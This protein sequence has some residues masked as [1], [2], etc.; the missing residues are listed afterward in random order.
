VRGDAVWHVPSV[1]MTTQASATAAPVSPSITVPW[2]LPNPEASVGNGGRGEALGDRLGVAGVVPH[3]ATT[4]AIANNS[5]T[6]R[7]GRTLLSADMRRVFPL[8]LIVALGVAAIF[9]GSLPGQPANAAVTFVTISGKITDASTGQPL[10]GACVAITAAG[11]TCLPQFPHTDTSGNYSISLPQGITW[12]FNFVACD[13]RT[14]TRNIVTD[15]TKVENQALTFIGSPKPAPLAGTPTN[16]VYLPN[17]TKTLGGATGWDTPF[18]VQNVDAANATNLE[19][20]FYRFSDG[21]LITRRIVNG[22]QS[23]RSFADIPSKDVDLPDSTQ[24][25]VVIRSFGAN[26]VSV[27]NEV[28][29]VGDA[30][31]GLSYTGAGA[32]NTTVY[33]PN[34]TRRFFGYDVPF[35][36]QNLGS[37]QA[38]VSVDF[39]SFDTTVRYGLV[40]LA[41]PRQSAVVDPDFLPTYNGQ[42]NS[43]LRDG[44]QYSVTV[45]S[46]QPVAVVVNAHNEA[47]APVAYSHNGLS[48]PG[49]AKLYAPFAAKNADGIGRTTNVVVQNVGTTAVAPT[50]SFTPLGGG[51]TQTFALPSIPAG[52]SKAFE[53]LYTNGNSA[54]S[55]CS[56]ASSSCL[57][58][59]L[60]SLTIDAPGGQ[61]AA[62]ILPFSASTVM[63]YSAA[64]TAANRAFLPNVTRTLGGATGYTT[65]FY[66]QSAGATSV[67]VKWYRFDTGALVITQANIALPTGGA[68]EFDPRTVAGLSDDTQYAV[69]VEGNGGQVVAVVKEIA[70]TGGDAALMY[71]GFPG[72]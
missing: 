40:V 8:A 48:A 47:G 51:T 62:V 57:G 34:V 45:T 2:N 20:N 22:L 14:V 72:P 18:I 35:I 21:C 56:G 38:H 7:A 65:P 28:Q 68:K 9:A 33:L 32:G 41:D 16:S 58:N 4:R 60:F 24:F 19:I 43:G 6:R 36:I 70:F 39:V 54:L 71:E 1:A 46:D 67:N 37:A 23:F 27:V 52:A 59:G 50:L 63:A 13:Y 30:F 10:V 17:I 15:Q 55:A 53:A 64:P 44:L 3:D 61:I 29:G 5:V 66:V 49:A 69:V 25:S 26:V 31:E 42:T 12:T 11:G